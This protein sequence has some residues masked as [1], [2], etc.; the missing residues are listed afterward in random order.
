MILKNIMV[1]FLR[2][3]VWL[4]CKKFYFEYH[5]LPDIM[6]FLEYLKF[7]FNPKF[8]TSFLLEGDL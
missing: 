8:L 5:S 3:C 7:H 4:A 1:F 2:G 6:I